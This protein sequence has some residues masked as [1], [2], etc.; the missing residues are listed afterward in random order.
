MEAGGEGGLGNCDFYE[1]VQG[2]EECYVVAEGSEFGFGGG[3][4][5][6]WVHGEQTE[7]GNRAGEP[8][9]DVGKVCDYLTRKRT[10]SVVWAMD[11]QGWGMG[12]RLGMGQGRGIISTTQEDV[13]FC[14]LSVA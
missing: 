10:A 11:G 6:R 3:G 7:Q 5:G 9:V 14:C 2:D 12:P 1:R 8:H 4:G 13:T